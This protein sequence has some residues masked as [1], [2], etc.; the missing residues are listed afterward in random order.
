MQQVTE[1]W[2]LTEPGFAGRAATHICQGTPGQVPTLAGWIS[3]CARKTGA[4][5]RLRSTVQYIPGDSRCRNGYVRRHSSHRR[6]LVDRPSACFEKI[7]PPSSQ[8]RGQ[9][10]RRR[11]LRMSPPLA[12][13]RCWPPLPRCPSVHHRDSWWSG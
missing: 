8:Q 2:Y 7:W 6:L 10:A 12:V 1:K 9:R 3:T 5:V 11:L 13:S 4:E